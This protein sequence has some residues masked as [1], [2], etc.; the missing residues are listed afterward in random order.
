MDKCLA[1]LLRD[2]GPSGLTAASHCPF[3]LFSLTLNLR[4]AGHIPFQVY[5]PRFFTLQVLVLSL[6]LSLSTLY[7]P[8]IFQ[9]LGYQDPGAVKVA[10]I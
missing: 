2:N 4:D 6:I 3:S 1:S 9:S 5:Y 7:P 10:M 8:V